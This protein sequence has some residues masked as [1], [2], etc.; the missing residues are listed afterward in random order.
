[1]SNSAASTTSE[2]RR[3]WWRITP[4]RVL[5]GLLALECLLWLWDH[6]HWYPFAGCKGGAVLLTVGILCTSVLL[7]MLWFAVALLFRCRFQFTVRSLLLLTTAIAVVAGWLAA[8]IRAAH[9]QQLRVSAFCMST[10]VPFA[11]LGRSWWWCPA[12]GWLQAVLSEEFFSDIVAIDDTSRG[13]IT[14][15]SLAEL[16]FFPEIEELT[17][18]CRHLG[19]RGLHR[20]QGL[21][22]LRTLTIQGEVTDDDM[23]SLQ[24]LTQLEELY[25]CTYESANQHDRKLSAGHRK[26]T[27]SGVRHLQNLKSLT[28]LS[29]DNSSVSDAGLADLRALSQLEVLSLDNTA[30]TDAGLKNLA[31]LSKL[32]EL[33]LRNL[34][35]KGKGLD[36]LRGLKSLKKLVLDGAQ[37]SDETM[38]SVGA[39]TQLEHLSLWSTSV[40][41][42]HLAHLQSGGNL[43]ELNL[44]HTSISN[45]GAI[46]LAKLSNLRTLSLCNTDIGDTG[47]RHLA[48]LQHLQILELYATEITDG[49]LTSLG[50]LTHLENLD[51][52][53]TGTT[54][55]GVKKLQQ[56]LPRCEISR[57]GHFGVLILE[58]GANP[59]DV[60]TGMW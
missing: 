31:A 25:I 11:S 8:Q 48:T 23:A 5:V 55:L 50:G 51:I 53:D 45:A 28:A 3:R 29:L 43:K 59:W 16:H 36:S 10:G 9:Q 27:D 49:G 17:L 44:N 42:H 19:T 38:K 56:Q 30:V 7:L 15:E 21:A 39:L 1:V 52:V 37:I 54:D 35:L 24:G 20:L 32:K 22:L 12:P 47:L 41:D 18:N 46:Q 33:Y 40:A 4:D 57:Y 13:N 58:Y 26:L 60:G 14:D 6:G 34:R 2:P